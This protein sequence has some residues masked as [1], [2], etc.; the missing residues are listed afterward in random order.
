MEKTRLYN[1]RKMSGMTQRQLA[2]LVGV[3]QSVLSRYENGVRDINK[4]EAITVYRIAKVLN[5]SMGDVLELGE[6]E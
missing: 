4:A 2:D 1:S 3:K 5:C 6:E